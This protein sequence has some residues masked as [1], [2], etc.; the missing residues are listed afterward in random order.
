MCAHVS[1]ALVECVRLDIVGAVRCVLEAF[2]SLMLYPFSHESLA[3]SLF[4][5]FVIST[6]QGECPFYTQAFFLFGQLVQLDHAQSV[7][8]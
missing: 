3:Y 2:D 6:E 1:L 7:Q 8:A 5:M 4:A